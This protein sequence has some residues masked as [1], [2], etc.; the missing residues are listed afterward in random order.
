MTSNTGNTPGGNRI[1]GSLRAA[2][3]A[4]VVRIEDH[5]DTAIDD[6]WS[7]ITDPDRLARWHGRVEGDLRPGGE[8][9]MYLEADDIE[10]TGRVEACEPPRRLLV[11]NRE[12]DESYRKGQG[13]PPFDAAIEV[14]LTA[15]GDQTILV[16]E[17]RGMPLDKIA[18]YGAGWQIHAENLAAYLAGRERG[19]TEARWGE[20]VPPYQDL[21]ANLD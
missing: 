19:D 6:L 15:D 1:L 16:L 11:T 9:R 3:G 21:A 5:Y 18:F 10:S 12:T 20:L 8:F 7:A 17:V 4:G 2:D 13:V 14:T